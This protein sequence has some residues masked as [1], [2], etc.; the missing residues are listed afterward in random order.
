MI[1]FTLDTRILVAILTEA[2]AIADREKRPDSST[3]AGFLAYC[4]SEYP[5][6]AHLL[7][8]TLAPDATAA[9]NENRR[10]GG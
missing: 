5:G 9:A 7:L 8:A 6:D 3:P 4:A 1:D 10:S 2:L